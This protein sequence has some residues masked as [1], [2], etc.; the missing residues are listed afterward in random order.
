MYEARNTTLIKR[1]SGMQKDET[2]RSCLVWE[3]EALRPKIFELRH[4]EML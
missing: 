3:G 2:W 1:K 4:A